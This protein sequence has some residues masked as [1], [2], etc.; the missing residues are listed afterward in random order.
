MSK[1]ST[2]RDGLELAAVTV[3]VGARVSAFRA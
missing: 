1:A 2:V 3:E